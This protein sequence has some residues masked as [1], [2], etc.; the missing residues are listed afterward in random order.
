MKKITESQRRVLDFI[1]WS[2]KELGYPPTRFEICDALGF[3]SPNSA[4]CHLRL[5]E[6]KK[7]LALTPGVTRGIKILERKPD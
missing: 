2:V 1:S 4:E 6:K 7:I 5:M 3:S